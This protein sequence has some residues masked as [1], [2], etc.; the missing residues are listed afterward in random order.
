MKTVWHVPIIL[1][2]AKPREKRGLKPIAIVNTNQHSQIGA[3]LEET[4]NYLTT[5]L[6]IPRGSY[7]LFGAVHV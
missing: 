4:R 5:G 3:L 7:S 1:L 2:S 6:A